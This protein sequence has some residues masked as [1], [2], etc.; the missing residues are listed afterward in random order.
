VSAD[1]TKCAQWPSLG[2]V[3]PVFNEAAGIEGACRTIVESLRQYPGQGLVI[4]VDDGS[5]DD[6]ADILDR[7]ATEIDTLIVVRHQRNGGYGE[8]LRTGVK[9]AQARG[10]EYVAFIDSDLTNPPSDLLKIGELARQGHQY[11][12]ASRF[13]EGGSMSGVPL[14]RRL[15]TRSANLVARPLFGTRIRDV[16][17]GFRAGRTDLLA[18]W[19]T[20]ERGFAVIVEELAFALQAGIEPVEFPTTLSARS[21]EQRPTSFAYTPSQLWSYLRHALRAF[22]GRIST[23][24]R[25]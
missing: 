11:I 4:A 10:L 23:H 5:A 25:G 12:K 7:L 18:G 8:A 9:T 1:E 14:K 16:T 6:S 13:I 15:W 19:P 3:V 21:D 17:N 20:R 22:A 2:V 24:K